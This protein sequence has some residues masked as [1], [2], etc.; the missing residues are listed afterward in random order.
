MYPT[1]VSFEVESHETVRMSVPVMPRLAATVNRTALFAVTRLLLMI[2][3]GSLMIVTEDGA[4]AAAP[5][6]EGVPVRVSPSF[7]LPSNDTT[8]VRTSF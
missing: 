2:V 8:T 6:T 4:T 3:S 7:Y 1:R 5:L